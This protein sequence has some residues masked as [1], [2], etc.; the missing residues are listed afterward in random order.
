MPDLRQRTGQIIDKLE[1]EAGDD[2]IEA[3][4][5]KRQRFEVNQNVRFWALPQHGRCRVRTDYQFSSMAL[6]DKWPDNA[7]MGTE[8][9]CNGKQA[10]HGIQSLNEIVGDPMQQEI[11]GPGCVGHPLALT[12]KLSCVEDLGRCA[13]GRGY[14]FDL[15]AS[16]LS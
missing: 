11:I 7:M 15:L 10:L 14:L 12:A 13:H 3:A 6:C 5:A 4:V 8:V 9:E 2:Q 16:V 1:A